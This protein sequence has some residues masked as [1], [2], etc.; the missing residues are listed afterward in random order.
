MSYSQFST[1]DQVV[2]AFELTVSDRPHLFAQVAPIAASERLKETLEETLDLASSISTEKARSELIITPI[3]LEVRRI[4]KGQISY[5]S[6][7]TFDVDAS[8]GLNGICDFMLSGSSSQA[9]IT[10]PVLTIVEAKDNDLRLGLGQCAAEMVAAHR[11]NS[12]HNRSDL[13]IYGAIST[14]T[15]WR[16]LRLEGQGLCLDRTEYFVLQ[17]DQILGILC[18]SFRGLAIASI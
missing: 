5:F 1:I 12:Q 11:F 16:F 7:T 2:S 8:V 6:G 13:P 4:F 9:L 15:N 3:L 17:L 14:G 18:E 10:A